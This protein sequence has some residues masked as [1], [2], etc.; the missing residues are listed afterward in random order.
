MG[1][2]AV[3]LGLGLVWPA[4]WPLALSAV[5][6]YAL[7]HALAKGA[8]FLGVGVAASV[9]TQSSGR[10]LVA[11][12][13]LWP[14]LA[15]AGAPFTS[16]AV[17]KAA[18]K[19]VAALAA[20]PWYGRLVL[21]LPLGAVGT[22]L[23]MARFLYLIW[24]RR[25]GHTR[26]P[27]GLW[28][29]WAAL[30]AFVGGSLWWWPEAKGA[31]QQALGASKLWSAL[32][33]VSLGAALAW[34]VAVAVRITGKNIG[35]QVPAGDILAAAEWLARLPGQDRIKKAGV[36][37]RSALSFL[38]GILG[39]VKRTKGCCSSLLRLEFHLGRWTIAGTLFLFLMVAIFLLLLD[40]PILSQ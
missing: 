21:L 22:A 18:L 6:I 17:A 2:L 37:L 34:A 10:M 26:V 28:L 14:A 24:P 27:P 3:A 38:V 30:L 39:P 33:P 29:P 32:W 20:S 40:I 7:H 23:L 8:L 15:L 9:S 19:S 35:I 16:G 4:I 12:G 5:L 13:L 25:A 36:D 11:V 31:G 1:Y